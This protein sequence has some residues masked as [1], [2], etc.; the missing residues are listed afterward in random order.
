[1]QEKEHESEEMG[2]YFEKIEADL[3]ICYSI[4]SEARKKGFD[5]EENVD[6]KIAKNMAERVEGLISTVAPDLIGSGMTRRIFELEKKYSPMDWRVA[7]LIAEEVAKEKFCRFSEK[8][9]AMEIGIRAG[10]AYHTGGIV[11]AP[12]E[13]F[14]E[15]KINKRKDGKEYLVPCYAG[16]IRGAGGTAAAFSVILTDYVGTKM[17][18]SKYDS[19][20]DEISRYKTEIRNYHERV[21]NLQYFPSDEELEFLA[22]NLPV[23]VSGDPTEKFEVSN[24]KDIPRVETNRIRGGMALVMAEGLAQK[25]PKLWKRI[26]KWGTEF[27]L[28]WGF[29]KE[30]LELQKKVKSKQK[31]DDAQKKDQKISPNYTYIKDLVAGRP[32]LGFPMSSGSFRLRYGRSRFSGYS[33]ASISPA[34]MHLLDDYI[35]IGTQLKVERPGKAASMTP[36]DTIDGPIVKLKDGSVIIIN[37]LKDA[38]K[39]KQDIIEIIYLGDILFNYG[40]FSENNHILVPAGYNEE[41]WA[42]ELEKKSVELFGMLDTVKLSNETEIN[43]DDMEILIKNPLRSNISARA[44]INLSTKLLVPL[45]PTY[46][47]FWSQITINDLKGII[48]WLYE[49]RLV[50]EENILVKAILPYSK[51]REKEKRA[52][53]IIG[54]PHLLV[55][56]E[57]VVF[58]KD[59]S[60]SFLTSL[61]YFNYG[62]VS[63]ILN[64][65]L[66]F[67]T[68]LD[69]VNAVSGIIIRDR[70]GTFIGARMGRPEKAKMRK[71]DGSPHLLFPVGEEGGRLRSFQ[72]ALEAGFIEGEFPIYFCPECSKE[73]IYHICDICK[74][75]AKKR[76]FCKKCNEIID[77][78]ECKKSNG[79]DDHGKADPF[80][81]QK[82]D[83]AR[84]FNSAIK[85]LSEK[86]YPD[87]IKGVR[88]TANKDHNPEHLFKGI[89]R[90]KHDVYVNKDGTIRFDMTELPLTHFKPKEIGTSIEKLISMGYIIDIKGMPL[91]D[92]AQILELKPQDV[93]MPAGQEANE[94]QSDKVLFRVANFIDELLVKLYGLSSFYNFESKEDL[95]GHYLIGLAPHIS[96]GTVVRIIGFSETQGLL[97]H[98]LFHAAMRR[99]CD[100]D[101]AGVMLLMDAFLNFSRQYLPD[102]RGAKTM[103]APLV[104]SS[105]I[106]PAEVDDMVQGIDVM[107][108]YSLEFYEAAM[109]YKPT[110]E[111]KIEQV[112]MR[113]NT[114]GQ[115]EGYGYTHPVTNINTGVKFSAY[116]SL[117]SMEEKLKGQMVLAE[118]IRAVDESEVAKF[119]IEKHFLKD[120]KGN[121]RKFSMQ[122]FR[123]VKCNEKFRRPPLS[124][125]CTKC[126]GKIIFTVAEGSVIKYLQP[127]LS[128][129]DKY[130]LPL[131]LKQTLELL[132][133]RI[134]E[135]FGK[136]K[137]SQQG[138]GKWFG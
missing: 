94:E 103:D 66:S 87:L 137:E 135:V 100:G 27:G 9:L 30:F 74:K 7:L 4:A 77:K 56:N 41:W 31:P 81:K 24:F 90:A 96:A 51:E 28:K 75:P 22:K 73:T 46:T 119:V 1:M 35:A 95:I 19:T 121:L 88:G 21:T 99:D 2:K 23:E 114:P 84:Y 6:I 101:E 138:L 79:T 65:L 48:S 85:L 128:L 32:V 63:D 5:P 124:G 20:E 12:L 102:T 86:T 117:P 105:K 67:S 109:N 54:I 113:L 76:Y 78:P 13:G 71:M 37:S 39:Y 115:Y 92:T 60:L 97:A 11:A 47:Y 25:A 45:H 133:Y 82:I 131:Y 134:E 80:R 29:L 14:I 127:M 58:E 123:C 126:G 40:D 34:T 62:S 38:K 52:L 89:L 18:Y 91:A 53:E 112:K 49:I 129:A 59:H 110:S 3:N 116:K 33:A 16:P 55:N 44:A 36:C 93:I 43:A 72:S 17:G 61:G 111:V 106:I 83:I 136:E 120:T 108:E 69:A 42:R 70:A 50:N 15:L 98:P 8:R 10:F 26:E 118:K 68:P 104:L 125:K 130:N 122:Q 132:N 57:F 107:H 64:K